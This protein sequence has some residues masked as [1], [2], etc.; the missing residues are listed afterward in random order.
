MWSANGA[1]L[2]GVDTVRIVTKL[3]NQCDACNLVDSGSVQTGL[4]RAQGYTRL[5]TLHGKVKKGPMLVRA[6]TL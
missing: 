2:H 1:R 3:R 5:T 4:T 6:H